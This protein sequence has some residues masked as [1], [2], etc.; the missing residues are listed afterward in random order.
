MLYVEREL[1][2]REVKHADRQLAGHGPLTN[3]ERQIAR[4][5]VRGMSNSQIAAELVV[6]ERTVDNHLQ[7]I[8]DRLGMHSRAEIA[9]W[10]VQDDLIRAQEPA[11]RDA[12]LAR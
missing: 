11:S 10:S 4:L 7:H 6:S 5:V 9:V 2:A 8:R 3:R 1:A 12:T